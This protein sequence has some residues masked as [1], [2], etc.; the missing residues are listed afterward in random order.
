MNTCILTLPI[1]QI[2]PVTLPICQI[3]LISNHDLLVFVILPP[4]PYFAFCYRLKMWI[5]KWYWI[6]SQ[7]HDDSCF[8]WSS[9]HPQRLIDEHQTLR[10]LSLL[11]PFQDITIHPL[12]SSRSHWGEPDHLTLGGREQ[13]LPPFGD[14]TRGSA[15]CPY[16]PGTIKMA[17][18]ILAEISL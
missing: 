5:N 14:R 16:H 18:K 12:S 4:S 2:R 1:C 13:K 11:S 9:F 8:L 6:A 17:Y 10:H 7:F 3:S 15:S